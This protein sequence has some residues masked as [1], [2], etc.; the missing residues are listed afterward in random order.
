MKKETIMEFGAV[1]LVFFLVACIGSFA[2]SRW[3][4]TRRR[5]DRR[6][7]ERVASEAVQSRQVRRA[8]QR[9]GG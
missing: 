3:L 2:L 7:R 6:H 1:G 8:R 9:R 5:Q 4:S